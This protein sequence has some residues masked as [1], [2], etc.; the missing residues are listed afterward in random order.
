M[1]RE[2]S[3]FDIYV[4]VSELQE[5][6]GSYI[7]KIYQPT[8]DELL[9]RINNKKKNKKEIIYIKN[10]KL[11]CTTQKKFTT[12]QKPSTFAM[13][14]RKYLLNGRITKIL[15]HEFDRII[16]IKIAKKEGEY[17]LIFELF[18]NGNIIL[19]DFDEKIILPLLIQQ[20][21]HRTI[22]SNRIYVPPP[23]QI[24]PFNIKENQFK[25]VLK[26]S[27]KDLVR[28]LAVNINLSGPYAEEICFRANVNKNKKTSDLQDELI[29]RIYTE[30]QK[31]LEIF[32]E[33]KFTPIYVKKE[34]KIVDILPVLFKNKI[35]NEF[36]EATSFSRGLEQFIKIQIS[37]KETKYQKK[38]EKLKRQI[39]QQKQSIE[40]F[41]EKIEKK[42]I[43]GEIIYLNFKECQELLEEIKL[44]LQQKD[45]EEGIIQINSKNIVKSFDPISNELII[46]LQDEHEKTV[47]LKLDFRKSVSENAENAYQTRKKFQEKLKGAEDEIENTKNKI[48]K[49][50][51]IDILE[52]EEGTETVKQFWFERFRWFISKEGNI[53]VAGRDAKSNEVVVKKYL[54]EGDRYVHADVQGAPSCIAKAIDINDN[55]IPISENT[56][57]E[58]CIFAASY[59]K[60]WNQFADAQS[61][62][63]MPEQVS[64][65]PQ[66]G[67]FLPKGAFVIRGKRNHYRCKLEIA[68]GEIRIEDTKKIMAGPVDSV[69][70]QSNK[71]IVLQSGS[72]KKN[73]IAKKLSKIFEVSIETVQRLLPPGD[74][75]IVKTEGFELN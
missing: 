52:Q 13:T 65:T 44:L 75:T 22:R 45:K 63:V 18:K 35:E 38:I 68:I 47:E 12:P 24:N 56:L 17:T 1:Q 62:W 54:K 74:V 11:L 31:F 4:I 61:Y 8:R 27:E 32:K 50:K 2:L 40:K 28:T 26:K 49:L 66:S 57:E 51:E 43:E 58:T 3:S 69:V 53:I 41:K 9:I 23:S 42:K 37:K 71:F 67:E 19:T 21:A 60:A 29:K 46:Y 70:A 15:Q 16:K 72:I 55:K 64:K 48:K 36:V 30:L 25:D 7:D 73:V 10:G 5:L 39:F 20:W 59:S 33:K 34:Q 14:C 6:L